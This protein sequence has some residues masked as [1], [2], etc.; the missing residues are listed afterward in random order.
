M[1]PSSIRGRSPGIRA[2]AGCRKIS[3]LL[4]TALV[5]RRAQA[6][7]RCSCFRPSGG[8]VQDAKLFQMF[9]E[10]LLV[11]IATGASTLAVA[12]VLLVIPSLYSAINEVGFMITSNLREGITY[13]TLS[14]CSRS[15]WVLQTSVTEESISFFYQI[16]K[17]WL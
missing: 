17:L 1:T 4:L 15:H 6:Y 7:G 10:K 2:V 14:R 12:T 8:G 13:S 3:R 11:G 16:P 9:E 5:E